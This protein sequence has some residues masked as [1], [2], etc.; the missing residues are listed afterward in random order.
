MRTLTHRIKS[1][2]NSSIQCFFSFSYFGLN[3]R[4]QFGN[5]KQSFIIIHHEH[6][7]QQMK[8]NNASYQLCAHNV[9]EIGT[10]KPFE[11]ITSIELKT[12]KKE[13]EISI[14]HLFV[15]IQVLILIIVLKIGMCDRLKT[16]SVFYVCL[17]GRLI[18]FDHSNVAA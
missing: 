7:P 14:F 13:E 10:N 8:N 6:M 1:T 11:I 18:A 2:P 5:C 9:L 15:V 3:N 12:K 17:I 4:V 16:T